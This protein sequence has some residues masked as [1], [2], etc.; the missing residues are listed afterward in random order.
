MKKIAIIGASSFLGKNLINRFSGI[1]CELTLFSRNSIAGYNFQK[2]NYPGE[3]PDFSVFLKYDFIIYCVAGGVQSSIFYSIENIYELNAIIPI[4]LLNYLNSNKFQGKFITF[5]SY[6]E[7]GEEDKIIFMDEYDVV[8]S[9]RKISNDYTLS[10]RILSRFS[11]SSL[12]NINHFHLILP[13]IYGHGENNNRLI[14]YIVNSLLEK[15]EL[16]LTSGEQIRQFLHISDVVDFIIN[17][18]LYS[19]LIKGIYNLT[20]DDYCFVKDVVKIIFD[21]FNSD[22]TKALGRIERKDESMKVLLLQDMK[23]RKTG[24]LPK[25]KIRDGILEYLQK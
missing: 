25:K 19:D 2:F 9:H 14:P 12:L 23:A 4:K 3:I 24:W 20:S 13:S 17:Y 15:K 11:N 7:I 1:N 5:G 18:V 16:K 6:F 10:K 22:Y 8:H 21:C